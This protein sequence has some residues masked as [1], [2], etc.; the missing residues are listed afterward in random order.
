[1]KSWT[2]AKPRNKVAG[3]VGRTRLSG[4]HDFGHFGVQ[5]KINIKNDFNHP[6][7]GKT[8]NFDVK[9]KINY[10]RVGRVCPTHIRPTH[11]NRI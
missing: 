4:A 11:T 6:L 7:A 10:N 3:G 2:T 8:L 5:N 9:I 1:M